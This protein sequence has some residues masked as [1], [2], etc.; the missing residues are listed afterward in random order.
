VPV[1]EAHADEPSIPWQRLEKFDTK[2]LPQW[3]KSQRWFSSP[4]CDYMWIYVKICEYM[5]IYLNIFEY[6]VWL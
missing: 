4:I 5:W 2:L 1:P 6:V 3:A